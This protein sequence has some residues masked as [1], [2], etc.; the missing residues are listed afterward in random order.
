MHTK[1]RTYC[2]QEPFQ[3]ASEPCIKSQCRGIRRGTSADGQRE[4]MATWV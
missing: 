4:A 3:T 1:S 2:E